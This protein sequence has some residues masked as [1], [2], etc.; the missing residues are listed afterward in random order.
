[1]ALPV[2][3]TAMGKGAVDERHPLSVGV[4]GYFM[5]TRGRARH[6]RPLVDEADVILF[7]GARTNQNGTDSW[8]LFPKTARYIHID[9]D[10]QE[11]GRNYEAM[12]LIGDAKL[13]LSALTQALAKQDLAKRS[14]ARPALEKT[15]AAA[16]NAFRDEAD[17]ATRSDAVPIRPERLMREL[18]ALLT[19]ESLVVSDASYSPIW[20]ANYLTAQRAG[21]RFFAGRGL[22]G[23]GWGLPAALGVKVA[24]PDRDVFC[25]TGD[26]AF[27]HVWSELETAKRLGIKVTVIVLNNQ[28]LGYQWH[29]ED[30]L[31]GDHTDAC[32][33]GPVDHAAIAR[34][35]GCEGIRVEK[36]ADFR[37]ALDRAGQSHGDDG[38]RRHDRSESV[39][40]DHVVRRS[41]RFLDV[42]KPFILRLR[43][44]TPKERARTK[45]PCS[46][47]A[48]RYPDEN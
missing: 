30:V 29:A 24:H 43:G 36:P 32:Q 15:I 18:N 7:V 11:V 34:A 27:A 5:G 4:I 16:R 44:A 17:S 22:A 42:V 3:T 13:T 39:S 20:A 37:P 23:L 12:R 45:R 31:Y 48:S 14:G 10:G 40:A 21:M 25:I 2:A 41:D 35:C 38:D 47:G 33:L 9:I 46:A 28:I 19:P 6:L 8:T 1:M 26:G